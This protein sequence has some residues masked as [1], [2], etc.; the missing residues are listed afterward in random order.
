[1]EKTYSAAGFIG[2]DFLERMFWFPSISQSFHE[3]VQ[4]FSPL[5][6]FIKILSGLRVGGRKK[7]NHLK[8]IQ[9]LLFSSVLSVSLGTFLHVSNHYIS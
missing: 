4:N 3:S 5:C 9:E 8:S 6:I 1:M 2:K 7:K